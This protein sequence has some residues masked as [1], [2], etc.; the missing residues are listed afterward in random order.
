MLP[1]TA[2]VALLAAPGLADLGPVAAGTV[3]VFLVRHG[4]AFSNLDPKPDLPPERLDSL[5][6]LGHS[7]S[8][9]A[10]A[11]L[12]ARGVVLVLS[13][14]A[15]RA[16][17]TAEDIRSALT[18]PPVRVE[19]RLR[20]LD[21]GRGPDGKPLD[22]DQRIAEWKAGRDPSPLGG[23]SLEHVGERVLDLVEEVAKTKPNGS[24]VMVAH[25]EVIGSFL[26]LLHGTPAPKRYPPNARNASITVVDVAAG[27][28]PKLLLSNFGSP[29]NHM[30][31]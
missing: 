2:I 8:R 23:E 14:P 28:T 20:P 26:G 16:R 31:P 17:G 11:A 22:W 13:S 27:K 29:E 12:R 7:Q 15:G 1:A 18:A 30:K 25:G 9:A 10:G 24:V 4:Q 6:A 21:L 19:Q 5:T 3:R